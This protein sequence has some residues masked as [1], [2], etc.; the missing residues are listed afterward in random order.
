MAA[1]ASRDLG[2]ETVERLSPAT[3]GGGWLS[4]V[5]AVLFVV[6]LS[7]PLMEVEKWIFWDN[8]NSV[9]RATLSLAREGEPVLAA[10][11]LVFVVALPIARFA[12]LV[13]LRW[14]TPP[15]RATRLLLALD[16][17]SM[18]DVFGLALLIV[19]VKIGDLAS[20]TPRAGFLLL[21]AAIALSLADSWRL[22][23]R[24]ET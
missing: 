6:G 5:A 9:L 17:W 13:W 4:V 2:E 18:L 14:G 3:K 23:R 16:K 12:G 11:V 20:V 8:E 24:V 19:L 7:S 21:L 15:E 22:Q 1:V 10:V